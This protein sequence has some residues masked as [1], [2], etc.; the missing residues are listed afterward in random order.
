MGVICSRLHPR[1]LCGPAT[2]GRAKLSGLC[3]A[4]GKRALW[5]LIF[6]A[7][8]PSPGGP[9]SPEA[10]YLTSGQLILQ[11]GLDLAPSRG[12]AYISSPGGWVDLC[13]P[14]V[15]QEGQK[16]YCRTSRACHERGYALRDLCCGA[17]TLAV[18]S[19][20]D[21]LPWQLLLAMNVS[22]H[23]SLPPRSR[24]EPSGVKWL[25][26]PSTPW[27]AFSLYLKFALSLYD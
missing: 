9:S 10:C 19:A 5:L 6:S 27:P 13:N 4:C 21:S 2:E 22:V 20:L 17:F 7:W 1:W 18:P 14:F 25:P 16:W 23:M 12:G 11:C 8:I 24:P 15:P 26:R 3:L